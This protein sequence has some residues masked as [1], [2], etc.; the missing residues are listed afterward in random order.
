[1]I[2]A[3]I[4]AHLKANHLGFEHHQHPT[5]FSAQELAARE[6]VSGH[7]VAKPL[8]IKLDGK[9]AIAVVSAVE[10]VRL[11]VLEEATGATKAE[12]APEQ[13]LAER[14]RPC[15]PGAEP[16]LSLFGVPIFVD[17]DLVR[18]RRLVMPAGTYRDAIVVDTAEW[19]QTEQ[20]QVVA[21]LGVPA[22]EAAP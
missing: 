12:M 18:E 11:S 20:V 1:M 4:E 2:P 5:A 9:L 7:R 22:R 15:E 19:M 14:F 8:V 21:N 16:P 6:H 10:R 3:T 13:E 17:A